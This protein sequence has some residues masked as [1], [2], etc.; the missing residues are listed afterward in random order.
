MALLDFLFGKKDKFKQKSVF[1]P[2][3]EQAL[4]Q[5]FQQGIETSPL[6]G[7]GS[8]YLQNLLSGAPGTFEAFEAP[9]KR[10]FEEETIPMI[11]ERFAGLGTGGGALGSS[12]FG[13]TLAREGSNLSQ[14][15]AQLRSGLQMQALPQA[16]GYAQQ[17]FSNL[18]AGLGAR[19]FEN[20]YQPG[21][22]GLLGGILSGLGG[23]FGTS[24]GQGLGKKA[25]G[26]IF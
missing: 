17:P 13:Q 21:D 12:A 5:Y 14:T 25:F 26:K 20:I 10:Q 3:Q 19:G 6:F 1:T 18:L 7:A 22:T 23:G 4:Q 2:E 9:F 15:L 24:F 8:N 11:A 16:L